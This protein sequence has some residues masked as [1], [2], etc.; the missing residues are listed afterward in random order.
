MRFLALLLL[1]CALPLIPASA[2]ERRPPNIVMIALDDLNNW[3]GALGGPAHTPHIDRLAA[4]GRLFTNAYCV[5]P[6]CNPSRVA[7]LTGLRPETTGQYENEGNFRRKR[8]GNAT[9]LTLPQRLQK[10]GYRTIS[11]GKIFHQGRGAGP[12]V[13]ELSDP[14]SWHEQYTGGT[15]TGGADAYL[16]AQGRAKWLHGEDH[17]IKNSYGLKSA[18]WGPIDERKED[19]NDWKMAGF[20]ADVIARKHDQPYFLAAGIFRPHA[21]L[22][23]PKEFFDLYPLDKVLV[24]YVPPD[25]FADI[26]AIARENWSTPLVRAMQQ[27][28]EWQR[29]VQAY[30][31]CIS[32]ADACVG[33]IL[34]AID[35]SPDRDNTI[36]ILWGD[37]G[38]QLGHKNRWEKFSLWKQGTQAPLI[39]RAPGFTPGPS[40][41]AVSFLDVTPTVLELV[42]AAVPAELEGTSLT[43]Q[44]RDPAARREKP[45]VVTYMPGNHSVVFEN[46]NYIRYADGSE[47]LYNHTL[48]PAEYRNLIGQPKTEPILTQL[49]PHL[50][51]TPPADLTRKGRTKD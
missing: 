46:W 6:A 41:R 18:L 12:T 38:W 40:A 5:T 20:C 24:P 25:E 7:L 44:L 15:G 47:E 16:D 48:D 21:P 33:R 36:V 51:A 50:P 30:L 4:S 23:A 2:A 49:R 17:G 43:P 42:G 3:I 31:A 1:A 8:P 22:L 14:V 10:L 45:A 19:T 29:A 27:A 34:D 28:G 35:R 26:P 32:Y 13:N 39:V 37:H 11:A 9:L